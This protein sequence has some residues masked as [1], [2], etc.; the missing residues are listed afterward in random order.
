ML[1][2]QILSGSLQSFADSVL[3]GVGQ[4]MLQNN[5]I[6]G[7]LFLLG[8]FIGDWVAGLYALL[9]TVAAT[10]TASL[11]GAPHDDINQGLYGFNGTLTGLGLAFYLQHNAI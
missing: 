10:E 9:G 4:V 1:R 8:I 11:F 6:T 3:R 7:L 5:P 2:H